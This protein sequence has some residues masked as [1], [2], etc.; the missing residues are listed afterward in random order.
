MKREY[1]K[2]RRYQLRLSGWHM[3]TC[4]NVL[5]T[6]LCLRIRFAATRAAIAL[7]ERARVGRGYARN[8]GFPM[9]NGIASTSTKAIRAFTVPRL[10]QA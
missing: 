5:R 3:L 1:D 9:P 8:R 2:L 4:P 6:P 7:I 10:H